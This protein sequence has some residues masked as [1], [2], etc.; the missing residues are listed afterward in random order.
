[1]RRT[2]A[3]R[4]VGAVLTAAA[5]AAGCGESHSAHPAAPPP[6][7][8][9]RVPAGVRWEP[10]QQVMLPFGVDGPA[11]VTADADTGYSRTPQGAAL[12]A[13]Q[14]SIRYSMAPD[15]TWPS[16]AAAVLVS[17]T[18]KDNWVTTRELRH[19]VRVN[20]ATVPQ[21]QGY[22]IAA[23]SAE[24]AAVTVYT[25]Y[26]DH[27]TLATDTV[28][29]WTEGDWRLLLPD[30]ATHTVTERAIAAVPAGA[31]RLEATR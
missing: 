26:S 2:R 5:L 7:D 22:T 1:M 14:H 16:V 23:W 13:I 27:S 30:P 28:V 18:G 20:P 15:G 19:Y 10:W 31:V 24:R 25:G 11:H 21:I 8:L 12:A 4:A 29:T 6:P 9:H 3:V 17:N